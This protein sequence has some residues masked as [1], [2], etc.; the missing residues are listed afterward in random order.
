M[1]KKEEPH[2]EAQKNGLYLNILML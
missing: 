1:N 2:N